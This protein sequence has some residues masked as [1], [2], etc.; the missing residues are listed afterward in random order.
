[1]GDESEKRKI[2]QLL[3]GTASEVR[4]KKKEENWYAEP[5]LKGLEEGLKFT[6][7][8][9]SKSHEKTSNPELSKTA[10]EMLK[11]AMLQEGKDLAEK[12]PFGKA[13]VM[14]IELSGAFADGVGAELQ[15]INEKLVAEY[16]PPA[17]E[18]GSQQ[19]IDN[20][21]NARHYLAR[22]TQELRPILVAG[23]GSVAKK[24]VEMLLEHGI[25]MVSGMVKDAFGQISKQLIKEDDLVARYSD[26]TKIAADAVPEGH[27]KV[28]GVC[29][30]SAASAFIGEFGGE[31]MKNT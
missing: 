22:A 10:Q 9:L 11:K 15:R 1:M 16:N 26:V 27:R 7:E 24:A 14:T 4:A 31:E 17:A 18:E 25:S 12:V 23:L 5:I 2:P 20:I 8:L 19:D 6:E 21:N 29:F 13:I 3:L 28:L 30:K